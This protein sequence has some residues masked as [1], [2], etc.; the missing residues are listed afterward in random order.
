MTKGGNGK[1]S[2][3]N[4]AVGPF[5]NS[6]INPHTV[7]D[8]QLM[9]NGRTKTAQKESFTTFIY[10]KEEGKILGRNAKSWGESL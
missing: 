6:L 5:F 3:E 2:E 10:N 9:A 7:N 4:N 8:F 1:L